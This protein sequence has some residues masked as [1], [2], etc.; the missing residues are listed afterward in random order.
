MQKVFI[1]VSGGVD[2]SIAAALLLEAGYDCSGIFMITHDRADSARADAEEVC[3]HLQIPLYVLDLRKEFNR[4]IDYFCAAYQ[5]GKTPNPC[6]YCNRLIKFGLLWA[7]ARNHGADFIATGHYAQIRQKDGVPALYEAKDKAKDQSY[8]LSM[9]RRNVLNHI[10]L[11]MG[12]YTK[13]ETRQFAARLGLRTQYKKD[14]Q[15]ICFIPDDDYISM[16]R[17]WRP[18][19]GISGNVVDTEGNILGRHEGIYR[20]TIGQRRG[21]GIA[22]GYPA[23]VVQIDAQSNTVVLGKKQDLMNR[24][25]R[26]EQI[27]WLIDPPAGSFL[28]RIKIRYNHSGAMA[29]VIPF[30]PPD[31]AEIIFDHPVSAI[32]PG[33]AA[34]MYLADGSDELTGGGGWIAEVIADQEDEY[35]DE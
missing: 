19:V 33:Q 28:A 10:L 15:E 21:L 23:Y 25:L 34:V 2:S 22:L 27:N 26:L 11:P 16:L 32:T 18:D 3:R 35:R 31:K 9:V 14:S 29:T 30:S 4:I 6:V 20:Y 7:Y 12:K 13:A 17:Q 1:A 24:K 8:V 5:H